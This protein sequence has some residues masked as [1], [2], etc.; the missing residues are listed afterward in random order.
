[1]A[2]VYL[3]SYQGVPMDEFYQQF[4]HAGFREYQLP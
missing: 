2:N 3:R 1:M 4:D